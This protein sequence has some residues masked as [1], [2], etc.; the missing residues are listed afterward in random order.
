MDRSRFLWDSAVG[1]TSVAGSLVGGD[2]ETD[3]SKREGPVSFED[4]VGV[5]VVRS[6]S[7][8]GRG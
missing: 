4:D 5:V 1:E 2:G 7:S 6:W 3:R 8:S